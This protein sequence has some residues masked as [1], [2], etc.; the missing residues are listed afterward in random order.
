[1]RK[2]KS[3]SEYIK[4]HY[5]NEQAHL[6]TLGMQFYVA[7]R[8]CYC[9]SLMH[10]F[11]IV[12]IIFRYAIEYSIKGYLSHDIDMGIIKQK[13]G[14]NL[15]KLWKKFKEIEKDKN[16]SKYDSFIN[17]FDKTEE[18]RYPK[19]KGLRPNQKDAFE[20]DLEVYL[21]E[22]T[23]N[24]KN[25]NISWDINAIDGLIYEICQRMRSPTPVAEWIK[26]K[27][28]KCNELFAGNKYFEK[29]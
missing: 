3:R 12:P 25:N 8:I 9:R 14:H 13:Y 17:Q 20:T 24:V 10:L 29:D 28:N 16:L 1:M 26:F 27:Y 15:K 11:L 2:I 18:I 7:G 22:T 6:I 5:Q 4:D 19:G 23:Y 21:G